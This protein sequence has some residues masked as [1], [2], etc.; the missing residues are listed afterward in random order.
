MQFENFYKWT[1]RLGCLTLLLLTY[2]TSWSQATISGTITNEDGEG[3]IGATLFIENTN[4]GTVTDFD[5]SY[6]LSTAIKG[7]QTLIV[8]YTGFA[9]DRITV[10]LNDNNLVLDVVLKNDYL[11]LDDVVVTATVNP[12]S[13]LESSVSIS[14]LGAAA[15]ENIPARTTAELFRSLPGIR[16]ESSGGDGNSN[17]SVRGIPGAGGSKYVQIQEDGLPVLSFGDIA[18]ATQ[19]IFIRADRSIRRIEFVRG[20]SASTL[21]TNAPGGV[22]N[23]V[24]KTGEVQRGSF[25]TTAGLDYRSTRTD[26]EYGSPIGNGLSFH[27]GGFYRRGEGPR[28]AGFNGNLGGQF[29]ANLTKRFDQGFARVYFKTLNDRSVTYMPMPMHITGTNAA[30]NYELIEGFDALQGG[31]NSPF[32][33]QNTGLGSFNEGRVTEVADGMRPQSTAIGGEFDYALGGGWNVNAKFRANFTQ[34]RFVAPFPATFGN[35]SE[36]I[37]GIAGNGAT[38]R[39]FDSEKIL[40]DTDL[41]NLNGN[42]YAMIVHMF[43]TELNNFNNYTNDLKVTKQFDAGETNVNLT[44]GTYR[45]VQNVNMSWLWNAYVT[46]VASEDLKPLEIV[47]STGTQI[48]RNGQYAYGVP[49][50]GNCCQRNYDLSYD[51]SAPYAAVG[52]EIN[53]LSI[54]ASLRWDF[55]QANGTYTS[56][57]QVENFDV[58]ND[59]SIQ[60]IERSVS[61]IDIG[62][63]SPVN[64][65]FD[66][67]SFSIGANYKLTDQSAAFARVSRGGVSKADRLIF[68]PNID[69]SGNSEFTADFVNQYELGYKQ[70]FKSGGVFVTGFASTTTEEASFQATSQLIEE[71]DY[72]A[73]GIEL[74]GYYRFSD[75][76][77]RTGITWTDASITSGM[78]DG[79]V[80]TRQ[81][82]LIYNATLAYN[83][84]VF[85]GGITLIGVTDSYA[86]NSNELVQPGYATVNGYLGL[87]IQKNF[88]FSIMGNNLFNTLAITEIEEAAITNGQTNLVRARPLPGR[89]LSATLTYDF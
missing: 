18:F 34:G 47:D 40:S 9:T 85:F 10:E 24:S 78:N 48:T 58:N 27:V 45:S 61:T 21:A 84:A 29:K 67:I 64:Y 83:S 88:S 69:A 19:D 12:K 62:N 41:S 70:R 14:T 65:E 15:I 37:A 36:I 56:T 17:I 39:Y 55:G 31:L 87:N 86:K 46:D 49:F 59:G 76:E 13:K 79:N 50:W 30:P 20:G 63:S 26:F 43:D 68:T 42:G 35:A 1:T 44:F 4:D 7:Q 60:P 71:D 82:D 89:S 28:R 75:L 38:A 77:F 2:V 74:E 66:Y 80:P 72:Q 5:G 16:A 81:S 23:M 51:L 57:S 25:A 8:S 53:D 32:L 22:I 3:L 54:D 6:K 11:Q 73:F 33:L 52:V